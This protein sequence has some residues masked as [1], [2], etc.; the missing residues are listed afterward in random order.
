MRATCQEMTRRLGRRA[1]VGEFD[2]HLLKPVD[3]CAFDRIP[4]H[5]ISRQ[6]S[7]QVSKIAQRMAKF[8]SKR[9]RVTLQLKAR[10]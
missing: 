7:R 6:E 3:F 8:L 5:S 1:A 4:E 9:P 2:A 10:R